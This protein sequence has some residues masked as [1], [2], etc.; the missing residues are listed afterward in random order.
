MLS[1]DR[2]TVKAGEAIQG[3]ANEARSRG[4]PEIYGAHLLLVLLGQE[5]G[6]V[7][8]VLQK[9]GVDPGLIRE[10]LSESLSSRARVTGGLDPTLSRDLN[11][12]LDVAVLD[13][14]DIG[15]GKAGP[16]SHLPLGHALF[17]TDSQ[18]CLAQAV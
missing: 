14:R 5:E 12:G 7:K 1:F 9:L 15:S 17:L 4:N 6:I 16:V 13:P 10:R 2:L 18:H 11:R 3:A 8:P